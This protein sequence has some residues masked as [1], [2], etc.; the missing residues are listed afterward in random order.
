VA[1][2]CKRRNEV[3]GS[4]NAGIILAS[5]EDLCCVQ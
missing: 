2:C 3:S 4:I 1:G 5:Q